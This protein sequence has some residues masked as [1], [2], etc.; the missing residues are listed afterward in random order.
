MPPNLHF[1]P[2]HFSLIVL[3][4]QPQINLEACARKKATAMSRAWSDTSRSLTG[5][6]LWQQ[7]KNNEHENHGALLD[8]LITQTAVYGKWVE[9]SE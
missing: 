8:L 2:G 1:H 3:E 4:D 7:T 5:G 6:K 9:Q